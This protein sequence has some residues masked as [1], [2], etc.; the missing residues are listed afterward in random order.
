MTAW[1]ALLRGVNVGGVTIRSA[2]LRAVFEEWGAREVRTVLASGNVTFEYDAATSS[3]PRIKAAVERALKAAFDYDARIVLVT[4]AE[5]RAAA[6]GFP[7]DAGEAAR[8]PWVVFCVDDATRDELVQAAASFDEVVDPIAP[9]PGVVYWNPVTGTTV[10]TPFARLLAQAAYK[11]RTTNR[12]LR[13]LLR[14]LG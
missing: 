12:N 14:I 10:D 6:D 1:V 9:G 8:Q 11:P 3:R 13:T 7:F 2:D 4:R 5:L